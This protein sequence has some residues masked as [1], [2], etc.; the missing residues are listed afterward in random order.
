M[1]CE[2]FDNDCSEFDDVRA[3]EFN[4]FQGFDTNRYEDLQEGQGKSE[5]GELPIP[6]PKRAKKNMPSCP[7]PPPAPMEHIV[8]KN[9][10]LLP[11]QIVITICSPDIFLALGKRFPKLRCPAPIVRRFSDEEMAFLSTLFQKNEQNVIT[12][13]L[14]AMRRGQKEK[15]INFDRKLFDAPSLGLGPPGKVLDIFLDE[16]KVP[17]GHGAFPYYHGKLMGV[18]HSVWKNKNFTVKFNWD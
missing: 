10:S 8:A 15:F 5:E 9:V 18:A 4:D 7:T 17:L 12:S 6:S 1:S 2:F 13:I 16:L 3:P 11:G 14:G